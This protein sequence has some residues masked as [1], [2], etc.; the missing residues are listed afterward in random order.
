MEAIGRVAQ[1]VVD[2]QTGEILSNSTPTSSGEWTNTEPSA[3]Q[4][5]RSTT[6]EVYNCFR[7]KDM[8]FYVLDLQPGDRGFGQAIRCTCQYEGD[9]ERR[10]AYLLRI[11]GLSPRER[12]LSFGD[13]EGG[14]NDSILKQVRDATLRRKGIITLTG[15]PGTGKSSALIC[16]VNEA[17]EANVPAVYTTITDLL[18]Y[19]RSAYAP[20]TELTFDARWDLLLRAEVLALDELD[21]FNTTP[22][23]MERFLR[24]MDERWRAMDKCVT[25]CATNSR[26]N[27]LP[28]K[29]ASRLRDGRAYV[30]ELQG[31][32]MRP[33]QKW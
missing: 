27:T 26:I 33:Y 13:L 8:K 19:L 5:D 1:R 31:G 15:K 32:D 17:R 24:L 30:F 3:K 21:E 29:V 12:A 25:L 10:R 2:K 9:I 6:S 23:A 18:D 11:D 14:A 7:C 28:D 4:K 22:W 20:N 16:A